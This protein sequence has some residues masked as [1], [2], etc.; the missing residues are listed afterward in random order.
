MVQSKLVKRINYR[1]IKDID[2]E[3]REY[4]QEF[5]KLNDAIT[6]NIKL[7][8]QPI[9]ITFGIKKKSIFR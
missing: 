9:E 4:F 2:K 1:E 3:T 5:Y 6:Y 7:F 8:G